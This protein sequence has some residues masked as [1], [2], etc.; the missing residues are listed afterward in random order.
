MAEYHADS[1]P[2]KVSLTVGACRDENGRP[3][4]F[5]S[6][7]HSHAS[8][9]KVGWTSSTGTI[10]AKSRLDNINHEYLDMAVT[11]TFNE[12]AK[13]LVFGTELAT[14]MNNN[15]ATIQTVSGTGANYVTALFLP[16]PLRPKSVS[17]PNPTWTN[18][19]LVWAMTHVSQVEYP[20]YPPNTRTV[21]VDGFITTLVKHAEPND[22]I[23]LQACAHNPTGVGC[24][25]NLLV[26]FDSA[27]QGFATG[28]LDGDA[29]AVRGFTQNLL[30]TPGT[31]HPGA[32]LRLAG[33]AQA[34]YSNTPRFE[35]TI[36]ETIVEDLH[37]I[38]SRIKVMRRERWRILEQTGTPGAWEHIEGQVGMFSFMGLTGDKVARLHKEF[39]VYL[40]PSGRASICRLNEG[41]VA[42]VANAIGQVVN[43]H[44]D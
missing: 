24:E 16:V 22:V 3:W 17:I 12:L 44:R 20:Y 21:D 38:T 41:N 23:I 28:D 33:M 18:H 40:M 29:W 37:T 9:R 34:E 15:I 42:Y 43:G 19:K 5:P 25:E 1:H 2:P 10:Q 30:S 13:S 14:R 39:H 36:V 26:L 32:R 8:Y 35:A 7:Q 31:N 11:P 6:I 27:Y 4:V